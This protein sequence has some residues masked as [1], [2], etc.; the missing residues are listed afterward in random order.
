VAIGIGGAASRVREA[1]QMCERWSSGGIDSEK[2]SPETTLR[3]S[4]STAVLALAVLEFSIPPN[5]WGIVRTLN[6][7]NFVKTP[8]RV[9][10]SSTRAYS[11]ALPRPYRFHIGASFHGKPL[12]KGKPKKETG[13]SSSTSIGKWC[14]RMRLRGLSIG[15]KCAGEDFFYYQQVGDHTSCT[16]IRTQYDCF[17]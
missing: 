11:T 4:Y 17:V 7:Q 14:D 6:L 2:P 16:A 3:V 5:A 9:P 15:A 8:M 10:L 12:E 1:Q 13:F